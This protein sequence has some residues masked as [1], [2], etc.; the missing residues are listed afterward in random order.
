MHL[1][2]GDGFGAEAE[3]HL[4]FDPNSDALTVGKYGASGAET[5][6]VGPNVAVGTWHH[7][8]VVYDRTSTNTGTLTLYVDG[9]SYG[10]TSAFAMNVNQA[11]PLYIG[12]AADDTQDLDRWFDGKVD[13]VMLAGSVLSAS[14][15]WILAHMGAPHSLGISATGTVSVNVTGVNQPPAISSVADLGLLVNQTSPAVPFVLS[16]PENE[17]RTLTVT[18]LSS[19]TA[20]VPASG[21]ALS[22][23]PAAWSNGD[24]GSIAAAGSLV[25]DH[26]TYLVSGSGAD[27]GGQSDN[28]RWVRQDLTGDGEIIARVREMDFTN[29]DAKAGVMLREGSSANLPFAFAYITPGNGVAFSTRT[30][31]SAAAT[32]IAKVNGVAAPVWLRVARAGTSYTAFYAADNSGTP[33]S[34]QQLGTA[35]TIT[36]AAPPN[37][38]GLAVTSKA[39]G[40]LCTAVFDHLSGSPKLGGERTVTITP[41]TNAQGTSTITLTA[42]DGVATSTEQFDVT[43]S[44]NTPP[45]MD[46][47][48]DVTG[49]DGV[50]V[51]AFTIH[52]GDLHTIGSQLVV[53]ATSSNPLLLPNNRITLGGTGDTRTVQL[54]PVPSE[55]GSATI[56]LTVSDGALTAVRT[57]TFTVGSGDPAY[58]IRAGAN[59]RYLDTGANPVNWQAPGFIDTAWL[60]GPA[61]LGFGDGDEATPINNNPSRIVTYFRHAFTVADP[62]QWAHLR[63]RLLRDDGAVLYLN[64]TEIY[65][66]NMPGGAVSGT[67]QASSA[68]SSPEENAY[69][70]VFIVAPPLVAG[71][72]VLAASVHQRGTTSS[73]LS[74]DLEVHGELK[75]ANPTIAPGAM[76]SYLDDGTNPGTAWM[77]AAFVETTAWK[78]GA[79]QL[80]YGDGDEAT[81]INSGPAGAHYITSYFRKKFHVASPA[82]FEQA[83]IR[84]LRDDGAVVYL[85]GVELF[86]DNM[87]LG[88]ITTTTPASSSIGNAAENTRLVHRFDPALLL[89]GEN[90]IAVEIHQSDATSSDVSFDLELLTYARNSVPHPVA[91]VSASNIVITWPPWATGWQLT[92]STDALVWAPV[93]T[94]PVING[95]GDWQVTLPVAGSKRFFRLEKP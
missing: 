78:S 20:V 80:G 71:T 11:R 38:V 41:A 64:G 1:G 85:N 45:T 36:M 69:E 2:D 4:H 23:A 77:T 60:V 55:T 5:G 32:T 6:I 42:S 52:I 93:G 73:D 21:I 75:G 84:L 37:R 66:S 46:P 90:V 91:K 10:T 59:W 86:R 34:W 92:A 33:G 15:V 63:V 22:A 29:A 68:L 70:E 54:V 14:E 25:E 27:I 83:A 67:T 49:I 28:F 79:A 58:F 94:T 82:N 31:A 76:W 48:G 65:R 7:A 40:T 88:T 51:S 35:Q 50:S 39:D 24:V 74:F 72:N 12:G 62:S 8:A 81:V 26:G 18:A 95:D 16:D 13:D 61:Q 87:P 43:V 30:T 44:P 57:F 19:N 47:V 9:F 56:T 89:P 17:A 53:T 3:L